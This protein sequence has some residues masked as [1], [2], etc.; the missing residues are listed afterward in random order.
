MPPTVTSA[1]AGLGKWSSWKEDETDDGNLCFT[2]MGK[3]ASKL[4]SGKVWY[5]QVNCHVLVFESWLNVPR[6][7]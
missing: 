6:F 7:Y 5:D 2:R 1:G 3:A 4:S